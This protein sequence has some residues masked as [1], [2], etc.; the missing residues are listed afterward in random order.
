MKSCVICLVI[1][2]GATLFG[3]ACSPL[4]FHASN[5]ISEEFHQT[6]PL[7]A[8]GRLTLDNVNGEIRI[9]TW[10][11][12][13]VRVDA[14]KRARSQDHLDAVKIEINASRELVEVKTK[15]P[16]SRGGWFG[17]NRQNSARVDYRISVPLDAIVGKVSSVNGAVHVEGVSGG[18]DASTVNGR[19][20]A[21]KVS[22]NIRLSVVNGGITADVLNLEENGSVVISAVNGIISL[23][24][25]ADANAEVTAKT[26]NGGI[27]TEF[28]VSV[29]KHFPLG[30][31]LDGRIGNGGTDVKLNTVNGQIRLNKLQAV[32]KGS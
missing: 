25:P 31:S 29:K 18:V 7:N 17:R 14:V 5:S 8:D 11:E 15:H 10:D 22:G 30:R 24:L 19:L 32:A 1:C 9:V 6:I 2:L 4:A 26:V 27:S 23:R 21:S 12:N 28:P 3:L 16:K 20:Y 13:S